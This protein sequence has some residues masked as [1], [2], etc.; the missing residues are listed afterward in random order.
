MGLFKR[1]VTSA[2]DRA[3]AGLAHVYV[4]DGE[5]GILVEQKPQPERWEI[6]RRG[7]D[8]FMQHIVEDTAPPLTKRDTRERTDSAWKTAA[9]AYLRV[10]HEAEHS[11][12]ALDVAKAALVALTSHP[13]ETGSGVTVA[14]FWKKGAVDYKKVPAL[15]GVD[16]EAYRKGSRLEV[17][18]SAS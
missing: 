11:A 9:E 15:K 6:I 10:N 2:V 12:A 16:L 1:I 3:G 17:R 13:S 14:Q 5:R 4:F 18:V 8:A 7:W